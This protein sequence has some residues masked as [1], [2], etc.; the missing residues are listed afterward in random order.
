MKAKV[1]VKCLRDLANQPLERQLSNQKV[2]GF[3]IAA[4]LAKGD[5]SGTIAAADITTPKGYF[6]TRMPTTSEQTTLPGG[7]GREVL[8][9]CFAASRLACS[10]LG[11]SHCV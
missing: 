10:L 5:S 2:G 8:A 1:T 4:Y 6:V 7:L 3:L 9:W 11:T